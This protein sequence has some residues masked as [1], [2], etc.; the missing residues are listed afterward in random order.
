MQAAERA[1]ALLLFATFIIAVCGLIYELL[2]GTVSSYLLGDSVYQ[3]SLV[4]GLFMAS[5]GI[6]SFLS[7]FIAG[8]IAKTFIVVQLTTGLVGGYSAVV[9]FFAFAYLDNYQPFLLVL[10]VVIGTLVGLEIPLVMRLLKEYRILRLNVSNVLTADYI[11]ALA[12]SLLFP[13]V[14]LPQLGLLRSA[15][16]FGLFNVFVAGLGLYVFRMTLDG[17]RMLAV[18]AAAAACVLIGGFINAGTIDDF[19]QSRL[20][21]GEIIFDQTTPYQHIV[22]SRDDGVLSLYLNG[23][24]QFNTLDE[25]RYHEALVHPAM[26][27]AVRRQN[28]LVLGGGDGLAVR[29]VLKYPD[30]RSVTLVDLDPAMTRL[31]R[32]NPLMSELNAQSLRDSRVSVVN[33]DAWK[34]LER[35]RE[36]YDVVLIDLPDPNDIALS[37]L[38]SRGFY[39]LVGKRLGADGVMVTQATSPLFAREA[40]WCIVQTV[41]SAPFAMRKNGQ[42]DTLPYHVYVPTFGEWG[43][44]LASPRKLDWRA[45]D[46]EVETRY[47]NETALEMM[48]LFPPDMDFVQTEINTLQTHPLVGYYERGWRAWYQ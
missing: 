33:Q 25:Y 18:A 4:I 34:F 2:A 32:G 23:Q 29:E 17:F 46:I 12:A 6:G 40:F 39:S 45:I 19:F 36:F 35:T 13:L 22:I 8:N 21:S 42:M 5:M 37:K 38:Y 28:I 24:L 15:L 11:G 31:F 30:V 1:N 10:S 3:F 27:L 26:A 7:R 44:V 48:P 16:L 14:L 47:L 9:L 20:Y 41:K 43:F